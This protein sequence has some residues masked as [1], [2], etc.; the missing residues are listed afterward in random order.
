VPCAPLSSGNPATHRRENIVHPSPD[1]LPNMTNTELRAY[2]AELEALD[3]EHGS[4]GYRERI[5]EIDR[6]IERR[7]AR[8]AAFSAAP[9]AEWSEVALSQFPA[10]VELHATG[11]GYELRCGDLQPLKL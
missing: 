7:R 11:S 10:L 8:L 3:T 6:V 2:R 4:Q 9:L 5:A 1:H